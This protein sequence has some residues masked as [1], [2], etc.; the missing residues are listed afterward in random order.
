MSYDLFLYRR[1]GTGSLTKKAFLKFFKGRPH[2]EVQDA[3]VGY[4]NEKTGVYFTLEFSKGSDPSEDEPH[5]YFNM[6]YYRPHV[7]GLEAERLL[8][9]M[10]EELDLV[11]SDT[12]IDGMGDGEY[13]PEGF[14]RGW[15][16][17]NRFAHKALASIKEEDEEPVSPAHVL[18]MKQLRE[19]WEWTYGIDE[20]YEEI[21]D[22]GI[23]VFIPQVLYLLCDGT[24]QTVCIWPQ[25]IPTAVPKVDRV[26]VLR[27]QLPDCFEQPDDPASALVPWHDLRHAASE[28]EV[29]DAEGNSL[30]YILM[31]YGTAEDAPPELIDFVRTVPSFPGTLQAIAVDQILDEELVKSR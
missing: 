4:Q 17:G 31:D 2:C 25:L 21:H 9:P 18:P 16:A 11:V 28:F 8:T 24:L 12:Q 5:I 14:L 22:Q 19:C 27:D 30:P 3:Q 15:N 20:L 10:V 1:K 26:L 23:D 6:N 29:V 7:F 13:S